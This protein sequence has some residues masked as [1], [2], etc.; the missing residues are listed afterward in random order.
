MTR[1][2]IAA[3]YVTLLSAAR[4][5]GFRL[6]RASLALLD[7][8]YRDALRALETDVVTGGPLTRARARALRREI[9]VVLTVLER[10]LA[11][12]ADRFVSLT[13]EEVARLHRNATVTLIAGTIGG[14]VAAIDRAFNRVA[15]EAASV[16]ASLRPA[17]TF[18]T[19]HRR[20][21]L[22][23]ADSLD[24]LL[25]SAVARGQSVER[26][27]RDVVTL[28]RGADIE[29][30]V[31]GID[32]TDLGGLRSLRSDARRIALSETSNALREANRLSLMATPIV[33]AA[34]WQLSGRHDAI[35]GN[36]P[37]ECTVLAEIDVYGYGPGYYPPEYWPLAPHP[38][39]QCTQGTVLFRPISEWNRPRP[40]PA[41]RQL[42]TVPI[43]E[44]AAE[45][46]PLR[47]QRVREHV[48]ASLTRD[49][50]RRKEA[51]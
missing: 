44:F 49:P 23:A 31:Y 40:E 29:Y 16:L 32:P 38:N 42:Q 4:T 35:P 34:K 2:E 45:W 13:V 10:R 24:R 43:E 27:T 1:A 5:R 50:Y 21:L 9:L 12:N 51:A 33:L 20:H 39:C 36:S 7:L 14:P 26:L 30:G 46:T 19:L 25:V 6:T 37:D 15:S 11:A 28:L 47:R 8:A 3:S 18:R 17:R 48:E 22:E 41:I